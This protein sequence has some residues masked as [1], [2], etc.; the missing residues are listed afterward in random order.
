MTDESGVRLPTTFK[1]LTILMVSLTVSNLPFFSAAAM[2][3][4]DNSAL[5]PSR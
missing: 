1:P 5:A 4:A 3:P 2:T